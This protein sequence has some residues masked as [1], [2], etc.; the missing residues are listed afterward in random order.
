MELGSARTSVIASFG[1][2]VRGRPVEVFRG[3]LKVLG[4]LHL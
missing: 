1:A 2:M 4:M 3:Y